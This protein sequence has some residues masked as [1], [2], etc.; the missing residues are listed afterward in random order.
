[1]IFECFK[2]PWS[3][4]LRQVDYIGGQP[5]GNLRKDHLLDSSLLYLVATPTIFGKAS[6]PTAPTS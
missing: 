4:M 6:W 1:M 3:Q 2:T 5:L